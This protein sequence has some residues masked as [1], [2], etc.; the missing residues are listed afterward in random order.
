MNA[1]NLTLAP[2]A[3]ARTFLAR[4]LIGPLS[5]SYIKQLDLSPGR[6]SPLVATPVLVGSL[7]R[8]PVGAP[9]DKFG[10]G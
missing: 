5:S 3:F 7:G 9:T 8:I 4:N 2:A 6:Q 1:R 10:G